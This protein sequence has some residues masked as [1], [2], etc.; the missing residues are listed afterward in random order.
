MKTGRFL[1]S[2]AAV[3]SAAVIGITSAGCS[4][5]FGTNPKIKD[6][7]IVAKPTAGNIDDD[8]NVTYGKFNK[9]YTYILKLYEIEDD[10]AEDVA[11]ACANQRELIANNLAT[12]KIILK[13]AKEYGV[14]ELTEAEKAEAK[15]SYE[16]QM[17]QQIEYFATL[18]DYSDLTE[19][20]ITDEIRKQRGNEAFDKF[21]EECGMTRDDILLW[22]EEYIIS[23]KVLDAAVKDI[24]LEDAKAKSEEM[25]AKIKAMYETDTAMYEQSGYSE[26]WVPEGARLVKHVLLGFD[27]ALQSEIAIYRYNGDNETADTLRQ[28]AADGF[29]EK[30]AEVQQKLDEMNEGKVTFNQILL[31]YSADSAGS[32]MYPDG[33]LVVPN[34]VSYMPEF[35]EAAFVPEKIGDRTVC[36]TDY[37]V[38]IM[39][40]AGDAKVS[41]ETV[42][43]FV[44]TAYGEMRNEAFQTALEQWKTE[45]S[46]ELDR[47]LL[48]LD[49]ADEAASTDS[50]DSTST[51]PQE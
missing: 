49:I 38:H 18:A 10:T 27:E 43:A 32:S 26:L 11:E 40:Y 28:Q 35:Q 25:I 8:M 13:K 31:D 4:V 37:G 3:L 9:Q 47:E 15:Q 22:S 5:Q 42:D 51:Q 7:E 14:A 46:Y 12:N 36:V 1:R 19:D 50:T 34:G 24:T 41:Q 39:I 29:A 2:A 48:R 45:Y 21:L 33:Y 23:T 6:S 17:E 30:I 16:M 44:E 20:Q